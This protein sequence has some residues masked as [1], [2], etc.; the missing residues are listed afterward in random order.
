[1]AL[2]PENQDGADRNQELGDLTK[3]PPH[4]MNVALADEGNLYK[5][6]V[7]ME[8]PSDSPYRVGV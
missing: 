4:G 8:G 5:W 7:T 2:L 6:K 1:M 3:T